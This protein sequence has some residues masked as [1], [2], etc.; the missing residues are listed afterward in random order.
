[1]ERINIGQVSSK[2]LKVNSTVHQPLTNNVEIR[3]DIEIPS[4]ESDNS[5]VATEDYVL[6]VRQVL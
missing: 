6:Q 2:K 3:S 1:M 5:T 4:V